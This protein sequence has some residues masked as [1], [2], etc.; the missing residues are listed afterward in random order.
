MKYLK[1][2]V[3]SGAL[4][5]CAASATPAKDAPRPVA[6]TADAKVEIDP[7]GKLVKVE[8]SADLP[9]GIRHYIERE[10]AKWT[11][12]H[13]HREGETGNAISYL[14]LGACAVPTPAGGYS[15]GLAYYWNGPRFGDG[16]RVWIAP[17]LQSAVGKF[18]LNEM[19]KVHFTVQPD[20]SAKFT[21][22]DGIDGNPR[23]RKAVQQAL[24][25]WL[26][27]LRFEP[28]QIGG[29]PVATQETLPMD[30]Q[31]TRERETQESLVADAMQ[32][33]QCRQA[34]AAGAPVG[35]GLRAA[36]LDS[37]MDVKPEI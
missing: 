16:G 1:S 12:K 33:Q 29:H 25:G 17:E 3:L 36:A 27:V 34:A 15:M 37:V 22:F 35:Q 5:A 20:G 11:F 10:V 2:F 19:V 32:S 14:A 8:A 26:R 23:A 28:E 21:S 9:E 6:F 7:D 30:F 24:I 31:T 18:Q 13:N 4:V